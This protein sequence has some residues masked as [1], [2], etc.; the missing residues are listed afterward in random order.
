[1]FVIGRG[2]AVFHLPDPT[3]TWGRGGYFSGNHC[4]APIRGPP[5]LIPWTGPRLLPPIFSRDPSEGWVGQGLEPGQGQGIPQKRRRP[6]PLSGVG[7]GKWPGACFFRGPVR[8]VTN[9]RRNSGA[10]VG[11]MKSIITTWSR[12]S[13]GGDFLPLLAYSLFSQFLRY[14]STVKYGDKKTRP[15]LVLGPNLIFSNQQFPT[16]WCIETLQIFPPARKSQHIQTSRR[17]QSCFHCLWL[18]QSVW[19]WPRFLYWAP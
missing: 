4:P 11:I 7:R 12:F 18:H 14:V 15:I 13:S 1:M 9:S 16:L 5:A 6:R 3:L 2:G 10:W 8:P 19:K 17:N